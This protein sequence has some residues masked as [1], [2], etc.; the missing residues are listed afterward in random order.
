MRE[1]KELFNANENTQH[2]IADFYHANSNLDVS[3]M[4]SFA[5]RIDVY[6][7]IKNLEGSLPED[8]FPYSQKIKLLPQKFIFPIN[9]SKLLFRR[10]S[11]RV[12]SEKL[13]SL[14]DISRLLQ[15]S[16]GKVKTGENYL[17]TVPSAGAIY[18]LHIYILSLNTELE[19]GIYHYYFMNDW[20]DKIKT[21]S[22]LSQKTQELIYGGNLEGTPSLYLCITADFEELIA[23]Y[24]ERGYRFAL[25]ESGHLA[26]N[27]MLVAESMNLNM[28]ALGGYYDKAL[29][30]LIDANYQNEK[31]LYVMA[32]GKL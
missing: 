29:A 32:V 21:D 24:G 17:S 31:V 19:K 12:F 15:L 16:Y 20:M 7:K 11:R 8:K 30:K 18:P 25:I 26:Q 3:N 6:A 5:R 10:R 14:K 1:F 23:K 4:Q 28:V 2:E 9:F 22:N 27:I 13:I